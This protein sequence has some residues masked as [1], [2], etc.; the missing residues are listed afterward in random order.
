MLMGKGR[1]IVG[2]HK[3]WVFGRGSLIHVNN[4]AGLIQGLGESIAFDPYT[5]TTTDSIVKIEKYIA[6]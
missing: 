5:V 2:F 4:V 3:K 6:Y 1:K